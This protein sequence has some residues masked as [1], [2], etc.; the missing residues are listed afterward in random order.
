[1]AAELV[2]VLPDPVS[3]GGAVVAGAD[4]VSGADVASGAVI[5][6]AVGASESAL[7]GVVVLEHAETKSTAMMV[8]AVKRC[9]GLSM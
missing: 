6:G 1:M 2:V 4:V 8:A 7:V 9:F 5:S 3:V